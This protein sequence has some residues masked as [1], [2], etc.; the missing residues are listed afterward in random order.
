MRTQIK[1]IIQTEHD[2]CL[3][4]DGKK[5]K[6]KEHQVVCLQSSTRKIYLGLLI[7]DT[8]KAD[9]IFSKLCL[10]LDGNPLK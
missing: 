4:F 8:Q 9:D 10:I 7:C 5:I 3:H 2:F 6:D 1:D